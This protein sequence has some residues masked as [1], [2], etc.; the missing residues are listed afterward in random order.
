MKI[1]MIY[2]ILLF[3]N[4]S[5]AVSM[6]SS[7]FERVAVQ[8]VYSE[9]QIESLVK[10]SHDHQDKRNENWLEQNKCLCCHTTLPYIFSRPFD[11]KS[12]SNFEKLKNMASER[13]INT[14]LAPWYR[15]DNAGRNSKPT[16]SVLNAL[17]LIMYDLSKGN[18]LTHTSLKAVDQI[19]EN[20]DSSGKLH[21]L[22]YNLEPFESKNAEIWGNT[23]A[24]FAVEK[25][26]KHSN[27][28]IPEAKYDKLKSILLDDFQNL[29]PNEMAI[30]LWANSLNENNSRESSKLLS[31]RVKKYFVDKILNTQNLNGTWSQK[32]NLQLGSEKPDVYS[33]A[34]SIIALKSAG[35]KNNK[36]SQAANWLI[37][38]ANTSESNGNITFW[39]SQSMNRPLSRINNL[40]SSDYATGYTSLALKMYLGTNE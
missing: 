37:E 13:V 1:K 40:F 30:L 23:M 29:K 14:D 36:M 19:F 24:I 15:E 2:L 35:V 38:K 33:T 9:E 21:W 12:K 26:R 27:H 20:F 10:N 8:E 39:Q 18:H 17:T 3:S 5:Y 22:D 4:T 25:M 6:C 32:N 34:I 7:L 11:S 31:A 28:Q 16:E